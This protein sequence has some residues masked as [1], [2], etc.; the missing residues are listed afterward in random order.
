MYVGTPQ[1]FTLLVNNKQ[2][3]FGGGFIQPCA[4]NLPTTGRS[5]DSNDQIEVDNEEKIKFTLSDMMGSSG[6]AYGEFVNNYINI[7]SSFSPK[8]TYFDPNPPQNEANPATDYTFVDGGCLENTGIVPLLQRQYK[9]IFAFINSPIAFT[10]IGYPCG[11]MDSQVSRLFGVTEKTRN[12]P[13]SP[14]SRPLNKSHNVND[15]PQFEH[16]EQYSSYRGLV[17]KLYNVKNEIENSKI[18]SELKAFNLQKIKLKIE[19]MGTSNMEI[20]VFKNEANEFNNL[21]KKLYMMR[22][23]MKGQLY[24]LIHMK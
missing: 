6:C 5:L 3:P 20:Q 11:G 17:E 13:E 2:L 23:K 8:F 10:K 4:F 14:L 12:E 9:T 1:K 7:F 21:K 16:E 19:E 22:K 18:I 24:L 15:V